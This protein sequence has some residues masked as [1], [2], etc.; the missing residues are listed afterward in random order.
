MGEWVSIEHDRWWGA[1]VR[2]VLEEEGL[3]A[4]VTLHIVPNNL[5]FRWLLLLLLLLLL[6]WLLWSPPSCRQGIEDGTEDQFRSYISF[7][8]TLGKK[9]D[10]VLDDG[11]ARVA[12]R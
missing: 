2:R 5:P 6:L 11:R 9:F 12:V 3:A 4:R 10:L 8:R 7:A 1:R